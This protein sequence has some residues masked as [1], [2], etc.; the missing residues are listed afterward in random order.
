MAQL[1][2]EVE[3]ALQR[4]DSLAHVFLQSGGLIWTCRL[5]Y[6]VPYVDYGWVIL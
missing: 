3:Y 2:P 5:L 6:R 4:H 1:I